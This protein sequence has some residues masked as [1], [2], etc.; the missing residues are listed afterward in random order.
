MD[1][2]ILDE[3]SLD[4]LKEV[5]N[6]GAGG[7]A[8]AL[9]QMM[10]K[11]IEMKVPCVKVLEFNQVPDILGGAEKI[12]VA[13]Y[14]K[15]TKDIT[16]NIMFA[17]DMDSAKSLSNGIYPRERV[18]EGLDEMD[19]SVLSEIGNIVAGSY[20]NALSTLTGLDII[21]SIPSISVDMAGAI[22]SVP[23]TQFGLMADHAI[24][25]ETTFIED[26]NM[27]SG[28]FFLLPE[29]DSFKKILKVLGVV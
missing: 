4:A 28:D 20:V 6:I 13:V 1:I 19:L 21:I 12:V 10:S 7:A 23:A 27:I 26:E 15:F 11:K 2:D 3:K 5:A 22:L 17:M 29:I 24:M 14:F 8:T 9:G 25:I 18:D 16:G